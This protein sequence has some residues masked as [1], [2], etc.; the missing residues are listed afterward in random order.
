LSSGYHWSVEGLAVSFRGPFTNTF[1]D[2]F[3]PIKN[4]PVHRDLLH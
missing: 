2:C 4:A 3:R 1:L